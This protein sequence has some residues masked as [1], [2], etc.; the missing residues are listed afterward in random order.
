MIY[1]VSSLLLGIFFGYIL[2]LNKKH[3][4]ILEKVY[5]ILIL[6]LIFFMG[7]AIGLND[8]IFNNIHKIGLFSVMFAIF[9]IAGSIIGVFILEKAKIFK[10]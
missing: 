2:K 5:T 10:D 9:T 7:F 3:S 4:L 1:I 6:F 8:T